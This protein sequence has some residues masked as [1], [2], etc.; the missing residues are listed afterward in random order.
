ME[1]F[2]PPWGFKGAV[3]ECEKSRDWLRKLDKIPPCTSLPIRK[4]AA[5]PEH[6]TGG[7]CRCGF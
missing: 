7:I 5:C 3:W 2:S 1:A 6:K 4:L